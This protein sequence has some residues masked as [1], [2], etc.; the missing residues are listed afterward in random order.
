MLRHCQR[1]TYSDLICWCGTVMSFGSCFF[2]SRTRVDFAQFAD[3]VHI[4]AQ[5]SVDF[6]TAMGTFS[7]YFGVQSIVRN[8]SWKDGSILNCKQVQK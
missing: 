7:S 8:K 1:L 2:P 4:C 3:D 6:I 5:Y